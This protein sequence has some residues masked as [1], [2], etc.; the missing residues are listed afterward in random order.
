MYAVAVESIKDASTGDKIGLSGAVQDRTM[1]DRET[2]GELSTSIELVRG[3]GGL[4]SD[5]TRC[6]EATEE[7]GPGLPVRARQFLNVELPRMIQEMGYGP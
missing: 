4:D 6:A 2:C 7:E 5:K 1:D 3:D